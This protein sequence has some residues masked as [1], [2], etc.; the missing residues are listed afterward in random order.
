[1]RHREAGSAELDFW[2]RPP[3]S[4]FRERRNEGQVSWKPLIR[5]AAAALFLLVH[6]ML[7][8][9]IILGV[10]GIERLI[11]YLWGVDKPLL[12]GF[13]PLEYLFQVIDVGVVGTFGYRG[14]LAAY[15]AFED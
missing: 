9:L 11:K 1:L 6:T 8:T 2:P 7:A 4:G 10:F 13:V 14:I 12:F 5:A 15:R 3:E